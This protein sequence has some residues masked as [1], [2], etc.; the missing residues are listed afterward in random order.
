[1]KYDSL[2]KIIGIFNFCNSKSFHLSPCKLNRV[3][4]DCLCTVYQI[5]IWLE[6]GIAEK[7]NFSVFFSIYYHWNV[8][9]YNSVL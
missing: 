4:I 1:M 5:L 3:F 2:M 9:S 8:C 6:D 7:N